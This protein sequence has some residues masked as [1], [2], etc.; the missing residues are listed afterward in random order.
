M[1]ARFL[2]LAL[3]L[4]STWYICHWGSWTLSVWAILLRVIAWGFLAA[5]VGKIV[6]IL[7]Y[8]FRRIKNFEY[9]KFLKKLAG[10]KSY[11]IHGGSA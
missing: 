10:G 9:R 2:A 6:G 7:A 3:V 4:A 1:G 11:S 5:V 8:K